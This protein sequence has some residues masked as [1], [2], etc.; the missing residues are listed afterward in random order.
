MKLDKINKLINDLQTDSWDLSNQ[1]LYEM[2]K[3]N[4]KHID[5]QAILAKT[6][7]IGRT[8]AAALERRQNGR[9]P[10]I[11]PKLVGDNFYLKYVLDVFDKLDLDKDIEI[12]KDF[13]INSVIDLTD[14]QIDKV[15]KVHYDLAMAFS[16]TN[17]VK[18]SF[19]SKYLHFHLP[20]IYFIYDSRATESL[21]S[22]YRSKENNL[23][24]KSFL[25]TIDNTDEEYRNFYLKAFGLVKE[26]VD[27]DKGINITPRILD[28]VLMKVAIESNNNR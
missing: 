9:N 7:I 20:N 8:Y 4:F 21:N 23:D 1:V 17:V 26:I 14:E 5:E 16:E 27:Q 10:I 25:R 24:A 12:L 13:K 6:F 3:E 28:N 18:R 11:N 19:A 22:I 15:L 2:C